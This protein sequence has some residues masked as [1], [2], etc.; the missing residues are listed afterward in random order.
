[1]SGRSTVTKLLEF[2][3]Y[4]ISVLESGE[5]LNVIYTD[6]RKAFDM[7]NHSILLKK[8]YGIGVHSFMLSWI[9]TYLRNRN[10]YVKISGWESLTFAVHSGVPQ[11]SH[12]GPL[13]FILFINEVVKCFNFSKRLLFADDL[14][15]YKSIKNVRDASDLQRDLDALSSWCQRNRLYLSIEKCKCMSFYRKRSPVEFGYMIDS[16]TLKRVTNI[17]DLGILFK[18]NCLE[19]LLLNGNHL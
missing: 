9:A 6:I 10:Q 15:L 8:L 12:L 3:N 5:Q 7:L 18:Q 16:N 11:G 1:M 2:S 13:L 17:R 19:V 4:S 14:K